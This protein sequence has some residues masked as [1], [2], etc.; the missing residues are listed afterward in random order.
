MK[1]K[2]LKLDL[3]EFVNRIP[4]DGK[5][6]ENGVPVNGTNGTDGNNGIDGIDGDHGRDGEDGKDAP[7]PEA[8]IEALFGRLRQEIPAPVELPEP[9]TLPVVLRD[10]RYKKNR[11][12]EITH[13]K[14][15]YTDG[16]S[17]TWM[18]LAAG[19]HRVFQNYQNPGSG[20]VHKITSDDGSVTILPSSGLGAVDLSVSTSGTGTGLMP[21]RVRSGDTLEIPADFAV[22]G[23]GPFELDGQINL[24]GRMCI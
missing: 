18:P 12:G 16:D 11:A 13:V 10:Q 2:P 9:I 23:C 14:N 17:S 21:Y 15:F 4:K 1:L 7:F 8:K 5:D 24:D 6:G 22:I 19:D 20:G 3:L